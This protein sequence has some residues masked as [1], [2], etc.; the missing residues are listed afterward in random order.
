MLRLNVRANRPPILKIDRTRD[1]HLSA[2]MKKNLD[3]KLREGEDYQHYIAR[4]AGYNQ[5]KYDFL[6][7]NPSYL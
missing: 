2:E 1:W 7:T 3:A 6:S 4:I 5:S